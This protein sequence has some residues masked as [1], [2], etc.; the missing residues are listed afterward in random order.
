MLVAGA[1]AL[2]GI[3]DHPTPQLLCLASI[4]CNLGSAIAATTLLCCFED[5]RALRLAWFEGGAFFLLAL[6]GPS[7]WLRWG[8]LTLLSALLAFIWLSQP[9]AA[10]V[11][12]TLLV[13]IQ[14]T[15]FFVLPFLGQAF[16]F[17]GAVELF[18]DALPL[19]PESASTSLPNEQGAGT[20]GV[21]VNK[22]VLPPDE[23]GAITAV[24]VN[25]SVSPPGGGSL[26]AQEEGVA[27]RL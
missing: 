5:D 8:M 15:L 17:W 9:M 6:S 22:Y 13:A 16:R 11:L 19:W 24:Q 23:Q 25:S 20:G 18:T 14:C 4:V 12:G 10:K 27:I 2:L 21:Q 7:S 1:G 3:A 26:R